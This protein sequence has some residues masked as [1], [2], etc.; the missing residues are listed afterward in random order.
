MTG[1]GCQI[2][3]RRSFGNKIHVEGDRKTALPHQDHY[4]FTATTTNVSHP[5]L[6]HKTADKR[7]SNGNYQEQENTFPGW[8]IK[9]ITMLVL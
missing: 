4:C 8:F 2:I 9:S 7:I 6:E 5:N 3:A 1:P